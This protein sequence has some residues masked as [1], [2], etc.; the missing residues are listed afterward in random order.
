MSSGAIAMPPTEVL[1]IAAMF[2]IAG[3]GHFLASVWFDQI[4]PPWIPNARA[5]TLLSGAAEILLALGVLLPATRAAAGWGLVAL[6][7]AVFPANIHMVHQAMAD[8]ASRGYLLGLWLRL[9]LQPFLMWWVWRAT[10]SIPYANN[11]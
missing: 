6:L 11:G 1:I 5:A 7:M 9:P 10:R 3:V 4:M 8:N 2:G